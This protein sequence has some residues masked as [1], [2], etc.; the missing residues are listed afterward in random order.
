MIDISSVCDPKFICC[1]FLNSSYTNFFGNLLTLDQKRELMQDEPDSEIY[2]T[3]NPYIL[4]DSA[5]SEFRDS[6]KSNGNYSFGGVS[7]FKMNKKASSALRQ[8][9]QQK[10]HA[11]KSLWTRPPNDITTNERF[12]ATKTKKSAGQQSMNDMSKSFAMPGGKSIYEL[13]QQKIDLPQGLL[14]RGKYCGK[15][16]LRDRMHE[17][18]DKPGKQMS[19]D[20]LST[21]QPMLTDSKSARELLVKATRKQSNSNAMSRNGPK[22]KAL[23]SANANKTE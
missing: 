13:V 7:P 16:K 6:L 4:R 1:A 18:G 5:K 10:L 17:Y 23:R 19:Q 12:Y 11:K 8:Y 14:Y 21:V 3:E 20:E 15:S 2:L 9:T 22:N